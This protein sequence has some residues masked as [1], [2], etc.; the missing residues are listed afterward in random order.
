MVPTLET[1]DSFDVDVRAIAP[2]YRPGVP[3]ESLSTMKS[4]KYFSGELTDQNAW[5]LTSVLTQG[6]NLGFFFNDWYYLQRPV[7]VTVS[8]INFKKNF[9]VFTDCMNNLL[10]YNFDDVAYT[11]ITFNEDTIDLTPES[12]KRLDQL[13]TYLSYDNN[14]QELVIDSYSDS[15]GTPEHNRI[16]SAKRANVISKYIE[17]SN[18]PKDKIIKNAYGEKE[19]IASNATLAGR[20]AN[21]RVVISVKPGIEVKT[22]YQYD[23]TNDL[24][25]VSTDGVNDLSAGSEEDIN[26]GDSKLK[27]EEKKQKLSGLPSQ[28]SDSKPLSTSEMN[29]QAAHDSALPDLSK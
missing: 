28:N 24:G 9:Q 20:N 1:K 21:R 12:K 23:S 16:A 6:K 5:A 18:I 14:I 22:N 2:N 10:P 3:D 19:H 4:Y 25:S 15:F 29:S 17:Q 7:Q 11:V 13:I 8:S 27:E 26:I